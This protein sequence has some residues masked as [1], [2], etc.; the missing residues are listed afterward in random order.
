M[1]EGTRLVRIEGGVATR[2][3]EAA[4]GDVAA[5]NRPIWIGTA[6]GSSRTS[7]SR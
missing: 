6:T 2:V 3:P 1:G 7:T 4:G 5:G